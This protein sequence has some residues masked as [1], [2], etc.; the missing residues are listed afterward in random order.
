MNTGI[1]RARALLHSS[2][3][4]RII[5]QEEVMWLRKINFVRLVTDPINEFVNVS[6]SS[7]GNLISCLIQRLT[8]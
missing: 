3:T 7:I 4:G 1:P 8:D 2:S 6:L 5:A